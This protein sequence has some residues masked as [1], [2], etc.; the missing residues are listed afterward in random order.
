MSMSANGTRIGGV[1]SRPMPKILGV[2]AAV[3]ALALSACAGP[4]YGTG[5]PANQQL[6]ED[7]TG[8]LSLAPKRQAGVD[9]TPRPGIV[10]PPST[11]V[12]PPPQEEVASAGNPAWPESPEERLAR[13]RAEATANQDNPRYRSN[14]IRDVNTG[15]TQTASADI[16][17]SES[18]MVKPD[19]LTP[20]KRSS[21]E[22][23]REFQRRQQITKQGSPTQRR[24]LSDPPT[25]YRQPAQTAAVDELGVDEVKKER[26]RRRAANAEDSGGWRRL[27]PWL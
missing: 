24:Y 6:V 5:T 1:G 21:Q 25:E 2:A 18:G 23:R 7:L 17:F 20:G 14:V 4:T 10:K 26:A 22:Q 13:V 11:E 15:D 3:S 27:I 16:T 19:I 9:Y 12:L 8:A